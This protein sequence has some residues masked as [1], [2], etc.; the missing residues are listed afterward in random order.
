MKRIS[1]DNEE[2]EGANNAYLLDAA[3]RTVL[4][5]TGSPEAEPALKTGLESAGVSFEDV[6][7]VLLTH[8]HPDHSGLARS[9][10]QAGDATVHL[11]ERDA[12]LLSGDVA[13]W[14][15]L[16]DIQ[17]TG[18]EE[19]G[20]PETKRRELFDQ[21]R[22]ITDDGPDL[23]PSSVAS[24]QAGDTFTVGDRVLTAIHTPGH[25]AGSVCFRIDGDGDGSGDG[26][27]DDATDSDASTGDELVAGDTLLPHYTPNVGGSDLRLDQPLERFLSTL[28]ALAEADYD[29][30]WPGHRGPI[31]D[32]TA[33]AHEIVGHHEQRAGKILALLDRIGPADVW[34]V[35][36]ELFGELEDF[37][38][39]IG[40][41]EAY[42][43]LDHL[44][45]QGDVTHEEGTYRLVDDLRE[46]IDADFDSRT[47][48]VPEPDHPRTHR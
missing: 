2:L 35:A 47:L 3:D 19:W 44:E 23:W 42:S 24:F 26:Y 40:A 29:R 37:H 21:R 6:D 1:L 12:P 33:R 8:W 48:S 14:E 31:D 46:D 18:L 13:A 41:G 22:D 20:V 43:H 11:H 34:T 5:D 39:M 9:I 27:G 36:H 45:T 4:I 16:M 7:D 32:P 15:E 38:I 10:Q 17:E 30:A 28:Y 25:T